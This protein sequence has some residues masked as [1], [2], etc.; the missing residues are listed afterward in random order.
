MKVNPR[1]VKFVLDLIA[2]I[3][4]AASGVVVKYYLT[5]PQDK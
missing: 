3:A 2:V 1:T 4:T 5:D